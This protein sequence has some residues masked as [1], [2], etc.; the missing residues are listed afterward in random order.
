LRPLETQKSV[1]LSGLKKAKQA[2]I[3]QFV[4]IGS[5]SWKADDSSVQVK[6]LFSAKWGSTQHSK[7]ISATRASCNHFTFPVT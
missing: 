5:F 7:Q 1:Q 4:N 6:P 3:H 2:S